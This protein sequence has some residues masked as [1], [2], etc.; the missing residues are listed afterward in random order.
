[1]KILFLTDGIYPFVIG[2]MQKH[3]LNLVQALAA[4]EIE[5]ALVHCGGRD[6]SPEKFRQLFAEGENKRIQEVLIEFPKS[7]KLPGHYLR[8]NR[9]YSKNIYQKIESFL[10]QFDL[11]YAQGFTGWYFL[12]MKEKNK[13]Q[14]P[15]VVNFHG[16]G[17]FQKAP[18]LKVAL[19]YR[20]LRP[21]IRFNTLKADFIYSFGGIIDRI[22]EEIG[23]PKD[24]ILRQSNGIELEWLTDSPK[25]HPIRTFIFIGR[26]ERRKGVIELNAV[27]RSLNLSRRTEFD[28]HLV[29][30]FSD[31]SKLNAVNLH[32]HGEIFDQNDLKKI[33]DQCDCLV[34]PSYAEG[35]PTVI[36]EAM[37]RGLVI[38][39]TDVG[40]VSEQIDG[41]GIL[42]ERPEINSLEKAIR[43]I[44]DL[45]EDVLLKMKLRSIELVKERFLWSK[46]VENKIK[47]FN[48]ITGRS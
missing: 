2:G 3:S 17:E 14:I 43:D 31:E 12:K 10:N 20:M 13:L 45:P 16:Y 11:I 29:G 15:I 8:E 34:C 32:Y 27:L 44:C 36:L 47:D 6:Y 19:Q 4:K 28:F 24:K 7:G 22:I 37:A 25:K 1:M 35:M 39:G 46:I 23:V 41:N 21:A 42:L 40:A 5:I 48:R 26:N 9:I 30:A 33:I 38:I 18:G